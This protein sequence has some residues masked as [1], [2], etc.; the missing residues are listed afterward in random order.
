M[1]ATRGLLTGL[2][3]VTG[4]IAGLHFLHAQD[5]GTFTQTGAAS[6]TD[7]NINWNN[8]SDLEVELKAIEAMPTISATDV[9]SQGL[10]GN[11]YSAQYLDVWPPLPGDPLMLPVWEIDSNL[12]LIDDTNFDYAAAQAKAAKMAGGMQAM[13]EGS[14]GGFSPDFSFP[15]NVLWLQINGVSNGL[16][17]LTLNNTTNG[18]QYQ[19]LS[20]ITLS[21]A[22]LS[23]WNAEGPLFWGSVSSNWTATTIMQNGR[24]NLFMAARSWTSGGGNGVPDWWEILYFGHTGIDVNALDSAGDGWSIYQKYIMGAAP[25][26]FVTPPA[27]QGLTVSYGPNSVANV[28]WLLSAGPVTGYTLQRVY[29]DYGTFPPSTYPQ[30]FN[31]SPTTD[32]VEDN[33]SGD[34]GIDPFYYGPMLFISYTLTADYA[35]GNSPSSTVWLENSKDTSA[36]LSVSIMGIGSQDTPYLVVPTLPSDVTALLLSRV[37]VTANAI[38]GTFTVPLSAISNG[39]YQLPAAWEGSADSYGNYRWW[40]QTINTS[41]VTNDPTSLQALSYLI[42]GYSWPRPFYDGRVQLKQN[43]TFLLQTANEDGPFQFTETTT[44]NSQYTF[45]NPANYA[46]AGLYRSDS[47]SLSE[48]V[49]GFFDALL[50]FEDNY[51]YRNFVLSFSPNQDVG[52]NGELTTGAGQNPGGSLVLLDPPTYQ[53]QP[54]APGVTNIAPLLATNVTQWLLANSDNNPSDVGI[55]ITGSPATYQLAANAQNIFGLQYQST[56]LAYGTSGGLGTTTLSAGGS[57]TPAATSPVNIYSGM[58][59]PQFQTV[60]YDFWQEALNDQLPGMPGFSPT[61]ASRVSIA[62]IGSDIWISGYAKMAI[63][64]TGLYAYLGQYFANAYVINTNGAVTT[65]SAGFV[66]PYGDFFPTNVG[67]AA[68]VTMPDPATGTRGTN[69]VYAIKLAV[70]GNH[71]GVMDLSFNGPDNT[72]PSSYYQFWINNNYD[73][74][75]YDADDGTNYMDD[76]QA[77]DNTDPAQNLDPNDPDCNYTVNGYR[78][79]PDNRDLEDFARLWVCG[80]TSNLLAALPAGSTVTLSWLNDYSHPMTGNP[81]IDIFQATD[82]DGGIEYLTNETSAATQINPAYSTYIG[83]LV[84]GGSIQLNSSYFS[85]WAGNHFIWCGVSNGMGA[86]ALTI[87]DASN[88]VMAQ[89]VVYIQ[90][91]DIKQMYERWTVGDNPTNAPYNSAEAVTEGLAAGVPVFQYPPPQDTNTPYI[92]FVHGW[93]MDSYDKDRFAETAFKRLYWQ[94][95]QGRFGEFRWPTSWGFTGNFGQLITDPQEKDNF[96]NSEYFAWLSGTG[97]LNKLNTLNVEYPG[98]VYVLAHSMGNIVMGEAL[99]LAGNNEVVNTY[100]ASQAAVTAHT[101]DTNV[102]NY[103]FSRTIGFVQFNFGPNTPNIYGN[104]FAGNNG[105]GAGQV[106]SY[107]NVNDYA[108]SPL[109][110][111]L[112]QLI[113]PDT[114]VAE[115]GALWNYGYSGSTNDPPP[116]NNFF[117]TNDVTGA[118]VNFDIVNILTNRYEVMAYA[119]QA[120]TTALGATP[121]V[122]HI[123]QNVDLTT[124]W[125]P[126]PTG[127]DYAEHFWHSAE[128]RGDAVG[129]WEYWNTLLYSAQFG[130]NLSNP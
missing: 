128:F 110:W 4:T 48:G 121:G 66:S 69:F 130:F 43:L 79:I 111:Q 70:D 57:A 34:N 15:S 28:S 125:P 23:S 87:S 75:D 7:T 117:K 10:E 47:L 31:V 29:Y 35:G 39:L 30:T 24:S 95:Y 40:V 120:Y 26:V 82:P 60:E 56:E 59:Q 124:L 55:T 58:A 83:R 68:L 65:N 6:L 119:A 93:N 90:L 67:P 129:E 101:Y 112:D 2:L 46:Y 51:Q 19:I 98:H 72:S 78:V 118:R 8:L 84:P 20:T 85:G 54:P 33:L 104:W 126:D 12:F 9:V 22:P 108:L 44:N 74:W 115:N 17:H 42:T 116:W 80:V 122:H 41:G 36:Q 96:D 49:Y 45:V 86:L 73:R 88:N 71:D 113:K 94:G 99:R 91:Q 64:N 1:K 107:Y 11:F 27:P 92:L 3:L 37:D 114:L 63:G 21:N 53:F 5:T 89:S 81:M 76:V 127:N 52:S 62:S 123:A 100:V 18:V 38:T 103:S 14:G 105:G 25:N 50:P 16:V 102:P 109:S 61:N 97:L 32:S 77:G 13:D 106:I